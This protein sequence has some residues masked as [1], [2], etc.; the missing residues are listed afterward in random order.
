MVLV[1]NAD[2]IVFP[3]IGR[4]KGDVVRYYERL[5]PRMMAHVAERPLSLRRYPKGL[6]GPGFFQK[7]VPAHYPE[8][9]GRFTVPR[10]ARRTG[11][12]NKGESVTIY[13][14]VR[15]PE[16]MA[17]LANQGA[18]EFHVPTARATHP[19]D[20]LVFD[21]DPPAGAVPLV[22]QAA[23][24]VREALGELGVGAVPVVTGSK[25]YHVV[26]SI[27][28]LV[29]G[30]TIAASAQKL[31]A[32]LAAR[33]ADVVTDVFRIA[34]RGG[35]VFLDWLRN[36]PGATVI[37]P[38]SLRARP[39]ATVAVPLT[40]EEL[41]S[42]APGDFSI[43]DVDRLLDRPDSLA[44]LDAAASDPRHLVDGVDIAFERAGLVFE[45]FDRFRS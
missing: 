16:H 37:A 30:A 32:L 45:P 24:I 17:Y 21:L 11:E 42:I 27:A 20:R 13:P 18:I 35:R 43:D 36:N 41:D 19:P 39:R 28:P 3:E 8:S 40:W 31:A 7:N 33:H 14:L 26:A 10:A 25:G 12:R 38:Y 2:R 34:E 29:D 6:S 9:I 5:A 44:E 15:L 23:R 22:R 1:T 4:T